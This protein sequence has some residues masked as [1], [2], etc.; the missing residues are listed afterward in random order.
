MIWYVII[1]K[2]LNVIQFKWRVPE[3]C[4]EWQRREGLSS[5]CQIWPGKASGNSGSILIV[6]QSAALSSLVRHFAGLLPGQL[7]CAHP[8]SSAVLFCAGA[9]VGTIRVTWKEL[10]WIYCL[11][12][13]IESIEFIVLLFFDLTKAWTVGRSMCFTLQSSSQISHRCSHYCRLRR[14]S[15]YFARAARWRCETYHESCEILWALV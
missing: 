11:E 2:E 5:S 7:P 10:P 12:L 9:Q 3:N 8:I 13:F 1:Y 4:R 6:F 14:L 15:H